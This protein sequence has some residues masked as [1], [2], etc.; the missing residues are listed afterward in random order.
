M[1]RFWWLSIFEQP[2]V[3]QLDYFCRLDTDSK[4][5]A[6]VPHDIFLI[7]RTQHLKYGYKVRTSD[8]REVTDGLWEFADA[9]LVTHP[10]ASRQAAA[11]GFVIPANFEAPFDT[12]Y[13][14]FEVCCL[15]LMK[16]VVQKK[17]RLYMSARTTCADIT[18]DV[19]FVDVQA[20][21]NNPNIWEF[22]EAVDN[23][24]HIYNR[25]WGDAPLRYA[26]CQ[27]F[28]NVTAEV[29]EFCELS[30]EHQGIFEP[31]C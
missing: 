31:T 11:N 8:I 20:F 19:R 15:M 28:F 23:S 24:N 14:N 30:Y 3:S 26:L 6:R 29:R 9:F 4:L 18:S 2:W 21:R 13:N 25:R 16:V 7:M 5:L 17:E 12:Y 10:V 1:I 22:V 27:M